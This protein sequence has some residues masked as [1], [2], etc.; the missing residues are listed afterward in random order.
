MVR[1]VMLER[2]SNG[3][4]SAGTF[5]HIATQAIML[6]TIMGMAIQRRRRKAASILEYI[7]LSPVKKG[8]VLR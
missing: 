4:I 2:S 8:S 7:L 3:A 1:M 6:T 5:I